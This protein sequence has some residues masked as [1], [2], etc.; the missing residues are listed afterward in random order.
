VLLHQ[1][2]DFGEFLQGIGNVSAGIARTQA[3]AKQHPEPT[4]AQ[5]DDQSKKERTT[6]AHSHGE[7]ILTIRAA[8]RISAKCPVPVRSYTE[9]RIYGSIARWQSAFSLPAASEIGV[10]RAVTCLLPL[11]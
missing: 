6:R 1:G 7:S 11:P 9:R 10:I 4:A 3:L 5:N 2:I 8:P